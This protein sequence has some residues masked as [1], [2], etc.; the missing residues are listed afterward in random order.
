MKAAASRI[1]W[2]I[3]GTDAT[4]QQFALGLA[5]LSDARLV[6]VGAHSQIAADAFGEGNWVPHCYGAIEALADDADVDIVY[7]ATP[8]SS[9][10]SH[11]RMC[12]QAGKAVVCDLPLA[13]SAV[14]ATELVT[15]ARERELLL[16]AAPWMRFLPL[17][18]RLRALLVEDVI[19]TPRIL[20]A[21]IG[22]LPPASSLS[23]DRDKRTGGET[24]AGAAAALAA[25]ASMAFG[26]PARVISERRLGSGRYT[27]MAVHLAYA[28]GQLAT[29]MAATHV[30]APQE[31]TIIGEAGWLRIHTRWW[32]PEAF[33]LTS[34][35]TQQVVHAPKLGNSASYVADEAMRCLRAGRLESDVMPHEETL[36]ILRTVDQLY[37]QWGIPALDML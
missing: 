23:Q 21:D 12:L 5:Y 29:L 14:E 33:T 30:H 18:K 13:T 10:S 36:A 35:V 27:Q 28:G 16:L 25:L 7:I 11:V 19:G 15:L 31:A 8:P 22:V 26:I 20:S 3:L 2:G 37:H 34:G 9:H 24:L 32:A 6:A 17:I 4:A 1:R